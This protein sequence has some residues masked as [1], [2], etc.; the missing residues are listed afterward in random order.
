MGLRR[1]L[2]SS[3]AK[4]PG[5]DRILAQPTNPRGLRQIRVILIDRKSALRT[6]PRRLDPGEGLIVVRDAAFQLVQD[7]RLFL[8]QEERF[9]FLSDESQIQLAVLPGEDVIDVE[10]VNVPIGKTFVHD[11]VLGAASDET[12]LVWKHK[13]RSPVE[14][15]FLKGQ[16]SHRDIH[17]DTGVGLYQKH[18]VADGKL[19]GIRPAGSIVLQQFLDELLLTSESGQEGQVHVI[20][21]AGAA[22]ALHRN[23]PDKAKVPTFPLADRLK[24]QSGRENNVHGP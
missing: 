23:S 4:K 19:K 16:R 22:P 15:P 20:C 21:E 6:S 11:E 8:Q 13:W 17:P 12:G 9:Q 3:L 1:A 18:A 14:R 24:V 10:P 7:F 5:L 2:E